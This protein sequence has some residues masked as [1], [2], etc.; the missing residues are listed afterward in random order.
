MA[1]LPQRSGSDQPL[2]GRR[3]RAQ[4]RHGRLSEPDVPLPADRDPLRRI[5]RRRATATRSTSARC[6]PTRAARSRSSRPTRAHT[7]RCASTTSRPSRTG[8]NGSRRSAARGKILA[9]PAFDPFNDGELSPGASVESDEEI[10]AWVARD[11]ETALHP[12]CTCR[13]GVGEDSVLDPGT[14]RVHGLEGIRVVDASALRYVTNGNIYAPTMMV[15]EKSADLILGNTPLA[16]ITAEFYRHPLAAPAELSNGPARSPAMI[17]PC[18]PDSVISSARPSAWRAAFP[19]R[20]AVSRASPTTT[21]G[22]GRRA[23][24]SCSA[25]S[26]RIGG[27]V[28]RAIRCALLEEAAPDLVDGRSRRRR[29]VSGGSRGR[30]SARR[31]P[32]TPPRAGAG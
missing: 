20:W 32:R 2:R 28:S 29:A 3:L 23:V 4:Q 6:T 24:P 19:R 16:P 12:S 7:R 11:A 14:M 10:L 26:T 31:G 13:M 30:R 25:T 8:A 22:R 15:A 9:Q 5:A 1:P 21:T 17:R 18:S 27:G